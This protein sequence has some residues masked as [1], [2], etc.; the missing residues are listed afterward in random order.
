[1]LLLFCPYGNL[2]EERMDVP[3]V[4]VINF[5]SHFAF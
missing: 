4:A 5:R 2:S 1:M 3:F